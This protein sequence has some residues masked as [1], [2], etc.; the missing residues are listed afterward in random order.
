MTWRGWLGIGV[1]ALL[2]LIG[3]PVGL[4]IATFASVAPI[5][6]G[7]VLPSG[8]V[9]VKDGY[10]S[11]FIVPVGSRVVLVDGGADLEAVAIRKALA[12][13]GFTDADV[14]AILLTHGH[15][16]HTGACA[17]F[18][19]AK[20]FAGKPELDLLAGRVAAR[21]PL[22]RLMGA[23]PS[24]CH[25][26]VGVGDGEVVEIEGKVFRA[27]AV[28]GHTAGSVAWYVDGVVYLGDSGS[29]GRSNDLIAAPW[30]FSDDVGQNARE[31]AALRG[32][33]ETASLPVSTL[34]FAHS[35]ALTDPS[36]WARFPAP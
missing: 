35:G 17:A 16:D 2:L 1:G 20:V 33:L 24:P 28:P 3:G 19:A 23:S 18:P 5:D 9:T 12:A 6:D 11:A 15:P 26:P 14:V 25:D 10:S 4:L 31:L 8:A 36:A 7:S 34:A 32:R 21:G 22:P 29:R 30:I 27:F 13:R